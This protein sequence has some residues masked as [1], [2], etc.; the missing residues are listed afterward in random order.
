MVLVLVIIA[1]FLIPTI[2]GII[3]IFLGLLKL[4]PLLDKNFIF[5]GGCFFLVVF[6][7]IFEAVLSITIRWF[8]YGYK[9]IQENK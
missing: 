1:E 9:L 7:K 2:L 8:N 4:Y 5:I 3:T 6:W